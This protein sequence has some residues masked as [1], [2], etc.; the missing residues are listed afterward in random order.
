[1]SDRSRPELSFDELVVHAVAQL[2][3]ATRVD[4][5]SIVP[6]QPALLAAEAYGVLDR[7][8]R[9]A[10]RPGTAAP[11]SMTLA[12]LIDELRGGEKEPAAASG[13]LV[14]LAGERVL[15]LSKSATHYRVPLFNEIG[16]RL[17]SEGAEFKAV[18]LAESADERW[19]M[20]RGTA[21]FQ[22][23]MLV[24]RR[25]LRTRGG[26]LAARGFDAQ[27]RRFS[28]TLLLG[29]GFSPALS[30]RAARYAERRKIPFGIWSGEISSRPTAR[31]RLRSIQ[32]RR[33]LARTSFAVAYGSRAAGYLRTVRP[34]LPVVIGR[35]T[36]P[37][38]DRTITFQ[39]RRTTRLLAVSRALRGKGLDVLVDAMRLIPEDIE[40]LVIGEGPELPRLRAQAAGDARV[41]FSGGMASN[42]VRKVYADADVFCFP[43]QFD[44]FGLV[45]VEAM[46]AGLTCI[47]SRA[48]GAVDDLCVA[49]RNAVIVDRHDAISW[50]Q[51]ITRVIANPKESAALGAAAAETI[52]QRWTLEHAAVAMIA[53]FRLG[54]LTRMQSGV[55]A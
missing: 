49:D 30:G 53:G 45:L 10:K 54:Q 24:P 32:R 46:A 4:G 20:E 12:Q 5:V 48:P 7:L 3:E 42:A 36:A 33:L 43:S 16:R 15:V 9:A 27:V 39:G 37:I 34:D 31:N 14:S 29:G 38:P 17:E 1:M 25:L 23:G 19:W 41:R 2:P 28:P 52:R 18:F 6:E 21:D 13:N 47:V 11:R 8:P 22:H 50:A 40:L 55:I 26:A 35:N 44:V 51:A